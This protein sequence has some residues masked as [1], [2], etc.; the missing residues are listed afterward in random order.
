M[1]GRD[2]KREQPLTLSRWN[3]N[4][5][6]WHWI[7]NVW[8]YLQLCLC[9]SRVFYFHCL[10]RFRSENDLRYIVTVSD[11]SSC[12]NFYIQFCPYIC[13]IKTKTTV[14]YYDDDDAPTV[15]WSLPHVALH[16]SNRSTD[17]RALRFTLHSSLLSPLLHLYFSL[18]H[19]VFVCW[20]ILHLHCCICIIQSIVFAS[21]S[22]L[23]F[24]SVWVCAL[25]AGSRLPSRSNFFF[26]FNV[27]KPIW[28]GVGKKKRRKLLFLFLS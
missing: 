2:I 16:L 14:N 24:Q 11:D 28:N 6:R 23:Y 10:C 8:K 7:A 15:R 12:R 5:V 1:V 27:A 4:E 18:Q 19:I 3:N 22:L 17:Y 13:E 26:F 21:S 25:I 9:V 20:N